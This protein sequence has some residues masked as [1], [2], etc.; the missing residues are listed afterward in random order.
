MYNK[1]LLRLGTPIAI[2]LVMAHNTHDRLFAPPLASDPST[3]PQGEPR[4]LADQLLELYEHRARTGDSG[5][6]RRAVANVRCNLLASPKVAAMILETAIP[7]ID[8]DGA[9]YLIA[10][11]GL[12]KEEV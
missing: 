9:E 11:L 12:D 6:L 8:L 1:R 5:P 2:G 4:P 10:E 7:H 3:L